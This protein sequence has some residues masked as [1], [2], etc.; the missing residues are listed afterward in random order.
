MHSSNC[1]TEASVSNGTRCT[2]MYT[3]ASLPSSTLSMPLPTLSTVLI[4]HSRVQFASRISSLFNSSAPSHLCCSTESRDASG[5]VDQDPV[6]HPFADLHDYLQQTFP[7]VSVSTLLHTLLPRSSRCQIRQIERHNH[8]HIR[9]RIPLAGKHR[10]K[11]L[12]VNC[13][14]RS[15]NCPTSP[16]SLIFTPRRRPC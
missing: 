14:S 5:P 4:V 11:T 6:W 15:V 9:T 16:S 8:K 3:R 13:P 10:C 7:L 1:S 12:L 2:R